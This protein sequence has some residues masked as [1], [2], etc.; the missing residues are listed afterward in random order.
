M[1][2]KYSWLTDHSIILILY[3]DQLKLCKYKTFKIDKNQAAMN[4]N[5]KDTPAIKE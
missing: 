2:E 1:E 5:T 4:P 3:F